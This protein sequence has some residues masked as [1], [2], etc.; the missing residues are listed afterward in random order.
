LKKENLNIKLRKALNRIMSEIDHNIYRAE[1]PNSITI[2][3]R[4]IPKYLEKN[5]DKLSS[6]FARL[7]DS[8]SRKSFLCLIAATITGNHRFYYHALSDYKQYY[9]PKVKPE[10]NDIIVDAGGFDGIGAIDFINYTKGKG[11]VITLEPSK[12]NYNILEKNIRLSKYNNNIISINKGAWSEKSTLYFTHDVTHPGARISKVKTPYQIEVVSIDE[13]INEL[14]MKSVSVIKMDVEGA[15]MESLR[16][17]I[18]TI[19]KFKPKLQ[20]SVYHKPQDLWEVSDFIEELN[21]GYKQY[22]GHHYYGFWETIIY[23]KI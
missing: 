9:N 8:K 6:V 11:T 1:L 4:T 13:L 17:C 18:Q 5:E 20:I 14:K 19:K 3:A 22:L 10:K 12:S 23:A 15:E 2:P 16:G 7:K 21:L